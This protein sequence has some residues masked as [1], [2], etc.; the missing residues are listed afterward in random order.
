LKVL[1]VAVVKDAVDPVEYEKLEEWVRK[2]RKTD[3]RV[4]LAE[5]PSHKFVFQDEWE[6]EMRGED[7]I[8][9][10]AVKYTATWEARWNLPL[11][12]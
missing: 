12:I 5:T 8:W 11:E 7:S 9:D 6:A 4:Y 2:T 1:V 3:D 10:R